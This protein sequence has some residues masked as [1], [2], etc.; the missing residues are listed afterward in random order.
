MLARDLLP[1][2]SAVREAADRAEWPLCRPN[3]NGWSRAFR[4]ILDG[5]DILRAALVSA[6]VGAIAAGGE[7]VLAEF[8]VSG[9]CRAGMTLPEDRMDSAPGLLAPA[10]LLRAL[11]APLLSV[12][13]VSGGSDIGGRCRERGL[14]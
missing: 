13:E 1:E 9:P 12:S 4:K 8:S 6:P 10:A 7:P 3:G 11:E 2:S 5:A 14:L